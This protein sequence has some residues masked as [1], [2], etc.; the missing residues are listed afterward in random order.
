M[1]FP[2]HQCINQWHPLISFCFHVMFG[3]RI[4]QVPG[5]T[6]TPVFSHSVPQPPFGEACTEDTTDTFTSVESWVVLQF[7]KL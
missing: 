5:L 4:I 2:T 7:M 1:G 3:H 6:G